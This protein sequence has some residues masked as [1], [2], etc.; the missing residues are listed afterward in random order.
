MKIDKKFIE[1][2]TGSLSREKLEGKSKKMLDIFSVINTN[3]DDKI[4]LEEIAKFANSIWQS[5]WRGS[6]PNDDT[7][8][9]FLYNNHKELIIRKNVKSKDIKEF[10]NLFL[11]KSDKSQTNEKIITNA[12]GTYYITEKYEEFEENTKE[13]VSKGVV[14]KKTNYNAKG[15]ITTVEEIRD[16]ITTITDSKGRALK[17]I[18]KNDNAKDTIKEYSYNKYGKQEEVIFYGENGV[19]DSKIPAYKNIYYNGKLDER[20]E[21]NSS[22]EIK[23]EYKYDNQKIV[24][25]NKY[26]N[27]KKVGNV[28]LFTKD[29]SY[30]IPDEIFDDIIDP[31]QQNYTGDCWLLNGLSMLSKTTWGR[32]NDRP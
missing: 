20:I 8:D 11:K 2:L 32:R 13:P 14:D 27:G 5:S 29:S 7:I 1:Q 28:K 23:Q 17:V 26:E 9:L 31:S 18:I 10:F 16:N 12:D 15:E 4:D 22:G 19:K 6:E 3:K 30:T 24:S 21:Y 25:V